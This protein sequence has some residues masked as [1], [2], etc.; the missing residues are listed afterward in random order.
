MSYRPDP[1][2]IAT[3]AFSLDWANLK[4]YVFPPFSVISSI[5]PEQNGN[6]SSRGHLH[7]TK[8]ANTKQNPGKPSSFAQPPQRSSPTAPKATATGLP[9][10]GQK[11][12]SSNLSS[13]AQSIIMSSWRSG[14][15]KQYKSYLE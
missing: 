14:T 6:G 4:F 3:N 10:I 15:I 12:E 13:S 11:L 9:L 7:S 1:D 8:L 5:S 2:A